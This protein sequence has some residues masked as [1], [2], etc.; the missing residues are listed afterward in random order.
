MAD[1]RHDAEPGRRPPYQRHPWRG[2]PRRVVVL[3]VL[4]A[5]MQSAERVVCRRVKPERAVRHARV[6]A[7]APPLPRGPSRRLRVHRRIAPLQGHLREGLRDR[8]RR[9]GRWPPPVPW[10][11]AS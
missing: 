8:E 3:A 10:M 6:V 9:I 7:S 11:T 4:A 1:G 5:L 2:E